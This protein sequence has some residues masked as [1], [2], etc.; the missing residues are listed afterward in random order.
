VAAYVVLA[1]V[2]TAY[3]Y[4]TGGVPSDFEVF[5]SAGGRFLHGEPLYPAGP[6]DTAFLYPPFAAFL[7]QALALFPL[8]LAAAFCSF[9]NWILYAAALWLTWDIA[10][11]FFA[12]P[13]RR[14]WPFVIAIVLS[15]RYFQSNAGWIQTNLVT[16]VLVLAGFSAGTRRRWTL[17]AVAF[18]VAA[19]I[20]VVPAIFLVWLVARAPRRAAV[21]AM[22]A[23]VAIVAVPLLWRGPTQGWLDITEYGGDFLGGYLGGAVRIPW[24]NHN[25][26]TLAYGLFV[27]LDDPAGGVNAWLPGGAVAARWV[28]RISA[29]TVVATWLWMTIRLA[30][31]GQAWNAYEFAATAL[32]ALLLSGVT[33]THH[34]VSLLFVLTVL[35]AIPIAGL[36]GPRKTLLRATWVLA[37]VAGVGRDALGAAVYDAIRAYRIVTVFLILGFVTMVLFALEPPPRTQRDALGRG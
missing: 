28:Y 35:F 17:A 25:L 24:Y 21:S 32:A 6:I 1:A 19:G 34:L 16:L 33:W 36:R 4:R 5:W 30:R 29:M 15:I 27:P 18:V 26:A 11:T 37:V 12:T 8:P 31:R 3:R 20:K 7:F 23:V 22:I 14:T 9:G 10:G 2:S 13:R